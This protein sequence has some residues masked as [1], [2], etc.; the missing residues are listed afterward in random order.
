MVRQALGMIEA[1]GLPVAI[2]AADAAVK[3]ANV[4]LVGYELAKGSGMVLIK[5]VGD[6]GAV[7]AAVEAGSAA[8]G[9]VGRVVAT[10]IIPRP[11]QELDC[12]LLTKE[13]VGTGSEA[14]VETPQEEQAE[15]EAEEEEPPIADEPAE[16]AQEEA[17]AEPETAIMQDE[18]SEPVE[19]EPELL[20]EEPASDPADSCNLCHDPDCPRRKGDPR[21]TCL[22]YGK[23][24]KEDESI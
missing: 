1:V 2:T 4:K 12:I 5:V 6:V 22:H 9:R 11:H 8:A 3:S 18:E 10:H 13:T 24:V 19:E 15:P 17:A 16:E 14:A 23:N 21:N 20:S 7:K